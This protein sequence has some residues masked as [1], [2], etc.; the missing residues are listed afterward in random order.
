MSRIRNRMVP[1]PFG[2]DRGSGNRLT[3]ETVVMVFL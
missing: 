1:L 3:W 2:L